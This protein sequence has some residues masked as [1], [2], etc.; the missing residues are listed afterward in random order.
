MVAGPTAGRARARRRTGRTRRHRK[1]RRGHR[2]RPPRYLVSP[3][4]LHGWS[5]TVP[6]MGR[7]AAGHAA[8]QAFSRSPSSR[9]S[10]R[11]LGRVERLASSTAAPRSRSDPA[12]ERPRGEVRGRDALVCRHTTQ[13]PPTIFSH[14]L[15]RTSVEVTSGGDAALGAPGRRWVVRQP[16]RAC[17]TRRSGRSHS[18]TCESGHDGQAAGDHWPALGVA[19]SVHPSRSGGRERTRGRQAIGEPSRPWFS[20][21]VPTCGAAAL[22]MHDGR[23]TTTQRGAADGRRIEQG[24]GSD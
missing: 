14:R 9:E 3:G 8:P 15:G 16:A 18:H 1:L 23:L 20:R 4:A 17:I 2:F 6:W 13:A 5:P 10:P 12:A 21:R 24:C 7:L 22:V 19:P 11:T